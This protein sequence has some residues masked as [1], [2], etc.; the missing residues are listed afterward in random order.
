LLYYCM[1]FC[2]FANGIMINDWLLVIN[3]LGIKIAC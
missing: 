3:G 1:F 2:N